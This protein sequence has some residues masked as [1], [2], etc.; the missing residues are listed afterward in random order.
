M[1]VLVGNVTYTGERR[2]VNK[3]QS[4]NF[5]EREHVLDQNVDGQTVLKNYTQ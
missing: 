1:L 2:N 4:R 3:F 5:Q